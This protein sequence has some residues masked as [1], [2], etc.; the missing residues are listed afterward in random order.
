MAYEWILPSPSYITIHH[1]LNLHAARLL[2]LYRRRNLI[3]TQSITPLHLNVTETLLEN[4]V[5]IFF[6]YGIYLRH[7][8]GK[9]PKE[10]TITDFQKPIV[11][12]PT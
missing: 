11:Q 9:F 1:S 2:S 8:N 7:T 6:A 4:S 12:T 5:V 3:I 10:Y